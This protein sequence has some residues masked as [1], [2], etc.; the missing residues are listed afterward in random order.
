M[1]YIEL[2]NIQSIDNYNPLIT[3]TFLAELLQINDNLVYEINERPKINF[4]LSDEKEMEYIIQHLD[5][6]DKNILDKNTIPP[7]KEFK[8]KGIDEEKANILMNKYFFDVMPTSTYYQ[9]QYFCKL[10]FAS[11]KT[12]SSSYGLQIKTVKDLGLP[13]LRGEFFKVLLKNCG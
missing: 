10:V 4:K 6:F 8:P 1:I 5:Y 12:F 11:C 13:A 2:E 7:Y 9:Y 3:F